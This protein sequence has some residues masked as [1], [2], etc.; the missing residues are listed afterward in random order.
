MSKR[1]YKW[2][3]F[4]IFNQLWLDNGEGKSNW[5]KQGFKVKRLTVK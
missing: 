4:D 3:Y 5:I 2:F 1:K